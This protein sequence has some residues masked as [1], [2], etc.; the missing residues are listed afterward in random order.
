MTNTQSVVFKDLGLLLALLLCFCGY[1]LGDRALSTPDEGRY[2]E[3]PREMA[4]TGDWITPRLNGVQYFEKPPL[5]YWLQAVTI[6]IFGIHFW[7][8]RLGV[9][10]FAV[11]GSLMVYGA[12]CAFFTRKTGRYAAGILATTLLY[13]V[14][15]RFILLDLVVSF[16]IAGTLF[17]AY[18][19]LQTPSEKRR[20][21][22][23]LGAYASAAL[24]CLTKGLIGIVL[25]GLVFLVWGIATG[26]FLRIFALFSWRGTALF[27]LIAAPWHVL[28]SLRNPGFAHFY[29]IGEHFLRYTTSMHARVQPFYFFLPMLICGW[30]P[31]TSLLG[32][33]TIDSLGSWRRM[34][35]HR[36]S[37][38]QD[39]NALF[40]FL[41]AASVFLFFSCSQSKLIPYI[42][43]LS[44]PLA[45]LSA[46][47]LVKR[48]EQ[49]Q[50]RSFLYLGCGDFV[51][52][53][54]VFGYGLYRLAQLAPLSSLPTPLLVGALGFAGVAALC[55]IF[56]TNTRGWILKIAASTQMLLCL[57][58]LSPIVQESI[59]P[60]ILPL[61]E[62]VAL[63][64]RS[65]D[66]ILCLDTYFQDLPVYLNRLVDI[67]GWRGELA[68]GIQQE[69]M[70][71]RIIPAER[72]WP[73]FEGAQRVFVFSSKY[74]Y[75]SYW[76]IR[77]FPHRIIAETDD[78]IVFV[79]R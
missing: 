71:H 28:V 58:Q 39:H 49:E 53:A 57:N 2:V 15:S 1:G 43:P 16:F 72:F 8:M 34:H 63:N 11:L 36:L 9:M 47:A 17:L 19:A 12:G 26:N 5:F 70:E 7:S 18:G 52:I 38:A 77:Q 41:W 24:A 30:V 40:L 67:A 6:Q 74:T 21:F 46:H 13:Y 10:L 31:W 55:P 48:E 4:V 64:L 62:V 23:L 27:L 32:A 78:N 76:Q 75:R 66:R 44:P 50:K 42:L 35:Q 51:V 37:S 33:A 25:P 68:F 22:L 14:H 29:F 65:E 69:N 61:A 20:S 59:N 45:L 73:I 54:S 56:F 3:I 60:S 79:N